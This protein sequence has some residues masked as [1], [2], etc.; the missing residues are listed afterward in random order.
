LATILLQQEQPRYH[1]NSKDAWTA[2]MPVHQQQQHH[3]NNHNAA[4]SMIA[5]T[6]VHDSNNTIVMRAM[7]PAQ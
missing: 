3:C 5:K 2:K 1:D 7:M 4:S 6:P